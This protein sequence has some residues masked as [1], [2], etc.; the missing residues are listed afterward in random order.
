MRTHIYLD[1]YTYTSTWR[2]V[3][4]CHS[5]RRC[6]SASFTYIL[7]LVLYILTLVVLL[8]LRQIHENERSRLDYLNEIKRR[9]E[10]ERRLLEME[11]LR[12]QVLLRAMRVL[13]PRYICVSYLAIYVSA[14][15]LGAPPSPGAT[16]NTTL[17]ILCVSYLAMYVSSY[18]MPVISASSS[19]A[20]R[21]TCGA[22]ALAA[23]TLRRDVRMLTYADVC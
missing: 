12:L 15:P 17:A 18:R 8:Y 21:T 5:L 4:R 6:V 7:T 14:I 9:A 23:W 13:I 2:S 3:S 20:H 16:T 11:L 10:E 22:S 19:S 1:I